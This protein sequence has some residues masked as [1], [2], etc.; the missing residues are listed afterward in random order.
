VCLRVVWVCL[1]VVWVCLRV[2]WVCLRVVWVCLR[3]VWVCLRVVRGEYGGSAESELDVI[4]GSL[5]APAFSD[6]ALAANIVVEHVHGVVDGLLLQDLGLPG[7]QVGCN[8]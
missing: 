8:A 2:V 7:L 5:R 4:S 6:E 3:V 1:R